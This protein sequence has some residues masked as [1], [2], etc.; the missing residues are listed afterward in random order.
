MINQEDILQ[1]CACCSNNKNK[2][3]M[4]SELSVGFGDVVVTIDGVT[5]WNQGSISFSDE[6]NIWT[7]YDAEFRARQSNAKDARIEFIGPLWG[8]TYQRHGENNW[9]LIE[10]NMGFA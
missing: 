4:R 7:V 3:N 6:D 10:Q 9:V 2:L 5:V 8:G 1:P